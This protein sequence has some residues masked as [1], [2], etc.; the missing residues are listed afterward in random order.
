MLFAY[1]SERPSHTIPFSICSLVICFD[2]DDE[3]T[4]IHYSLRRT[5]CNL[6]PRRSRLSQ[7]SPQGS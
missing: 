7:Y 5:A 2:D 3:M 4:F 1:R 6:V